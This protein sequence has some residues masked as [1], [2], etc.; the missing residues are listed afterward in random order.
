MVTS[1]T[2]SRGVGKEDA[3][4]EQVA[5]PVYDLEIVK[6]C[7][8]AGDV[9]YSGKAES[10]YEALG[11]T[12]ETA[13][14]CVGSLTEYRKSISYR[15]EQPFDD[16]VA[17]RYCPKPDGTKRLYVKFRVTSSDVNEVYVTSF[18]ISNGAT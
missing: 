9:L 2:S 17:W 14:A 11:F 3:E 12:F 16:Y 6:A 15:K 5:G 1:P 13:N 10:H 7:C 18:H 8:D 4:C